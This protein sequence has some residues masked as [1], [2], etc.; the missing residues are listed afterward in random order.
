MQ[1]WR[2]QNTNVRRLLPKT[3]AT[4]KESRSRV[5]CDAGCKDGEN[6]IQMSGGC[7]LKTA[8]T[9]EFRVEPYPSKQT[10]GG[11]KILPLMDFV[12][13]PVC[14]AKMCISE[15]PGNT[16]SG[17]HLGD[18][19]PSV[20]SQGMPCQVLWSGMLEMGRGGHQELSLKKQGSV[21]SYLTRNPTR[22][23]DFVASILK[24]LTISPQP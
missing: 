12:R 11:L 18:G 23:D 3:A 9:T 17:H 24:I 22:P 8:A 5:V 21:L 16:H 2:T 19:G 6:I 20:C 1:G 15:N 14:W 13:G 7:S 10:E 4:L